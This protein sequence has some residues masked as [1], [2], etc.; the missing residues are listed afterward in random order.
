L[1]LTLFQPQN[2]LAVSLNNFKAFV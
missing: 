1:K 2:N